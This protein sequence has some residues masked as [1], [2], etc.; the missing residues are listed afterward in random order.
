MLLLRLWLLIFSKTTYVHENPIIEGYM[1]IDWEEIQES[2]LI[3][4]LLTR[5]ILTEIFR[6]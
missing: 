3:F 2:I 6:F 5:G 1:F 4:S